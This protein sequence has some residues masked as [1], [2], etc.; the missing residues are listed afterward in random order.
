MLMELLEQ[1]RTWLLAH[2]RDLIAPT[3]WRAFEAG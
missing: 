2:D 3:P 1:S